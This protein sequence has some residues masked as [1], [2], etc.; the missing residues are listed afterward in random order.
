MGTNRHP[1]MGLRRITNPIGE[2]VAGEEIL[3]RHAV[4]V[5]TTD[6]F[7]TDMHYRTQKGLKFLDEI[8]TL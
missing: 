6:V 2:N 7:F 8:I 3:L 4:N 5:T 1:N